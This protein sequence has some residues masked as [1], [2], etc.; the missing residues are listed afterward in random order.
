[1]CEL[2]DY[3]RLLWAK[4]GHTYCTNCSK[5]VKQDSAASISEHFSK[6]PKQSRFY[7]LAP[8]EQTKFD[9]K[10]WT[11]QKALW[12]SLGFQRIALQGSK[13]DQIID[14][15][16]QET[17]PTKFDSLAIVIDRMSMPE[18]PQKDGRLLEA[19]E[20]AF[21]HGKGAL[22][23]AFV[24]KDSLKW[25]IEKYSIHFRC[26]TCSID[27]RKPEPQFFSFNSPLGACA[28]CSGFGFNLDLD[29][30]LI[31]PDPSKSLK[32]GAIDPFTKPA[33]QEWEEDL[34]IFCKKHNIPLTKKYSELTKDEKKLIW[35]GDG[36]RKPFPGIKGC[37]EELKKWKYKLHVRV[38]IRRY[39]SPRLCNAC[40]GS[41]LRK[42]VLAVK[43]T[44]KKGEK[45]D[46]A[47][48][49]KLPI[50][51]AFPLFQNLTLTKAEQ[52]ISKEVL[53][54]VQ[55]RLHFLN[56]VGVGYLT[57]NRLAKTLSGGECQRINL[58]TQLG[59]KLCS[60]LYVLDEPSIGLHP[61]DTEKLIG[62]LHELR[63][64]G[65]TLVVV[66]HDLDVIGSADHFVEIG[67]FSGHKGGEVIT[68]GSIPEVFQDSKSLTAKYMSGAASI[69]KRTERRPGS[70]KT[71]KITGA[72][73]NNLQDVT[74]EF[75]LQKFVAVSGVSG[76]GKTTIVHKTFYNALAKL[77]YKENL[78]IGKFHRIYGADQV[79]EIVLLDQKPIGRSSRS[80]PATYL[81][82]YDD[83]R[84]VFANQSLS[85][86]RGY[87]PQYFSFNVDGGRCPVCKGEGEI[88]LD[89]HFMADLKIPCEECDGKRF[90]KKILEVEHKGKNIHQV[91]HST[92]DECFELFRE[93]TAITSKLQLLRSV[94]L[95]YLELG[96]SS[97]TLSGGESQ[98]LKIASVLQDR[99]GSNVL[100]VF[101]E[102]TT[103]LHVEDVKKL[104]G[105]MHDL[106]D[107]GNTIVVIEHN[108]ELISHADW[109]I[110]MGPGG[111][112]EGGRLV[113]AG[114]PEDLISNSESLTGRFLKNVFEGKRG[115]KT[116]S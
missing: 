34:F 13:E 16:E 31:V 46:I 104:L 98:R 76:S 28:E 37:F 80:N 62:L 70:G 79:R 53:L 64:L 51:E 38:F 9:K 107:Q 2:Y 87:T 50:K 44:S 45:I 21:V 69:P 67:P 111:G 22:A 99:S 55:N 102:P 17:P 106:V 93:N 15:A 113:A 97:T 83:I 40:K 25:K 20:Q 94:G 47:D 24:E 115:F 77:F 1:M 103:G 110:D 100:Y 96:Q 78:E 74:V 105:V 81:K 12:N 84:S 48:V 71:I 60:T 33:Y 86:R 32:V 95:G 49:L 85:I 29:E 82:I 19:F 65:N 116:K 27:Y 4:I 61:A 18:N 7:I 56:E 112:S 54:Q 68:S 73:E 92:I 6:L 36:S 30:N 39:Q 10:L 8:I 72:C 26:E 23:V 35:N 89:M 41:R 108:L 57:L 75:P 63:D 3:F 101:D 114:T 88:S 52:K 14:L 11:E 91:L 109:V 59:N 43:L 66:E 90:K 5:E 42:E 58:A